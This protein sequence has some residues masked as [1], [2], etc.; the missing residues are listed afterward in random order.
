MKKIQHPLYNRWRLIRYHTTVETSQRWQAYG[1]RG[2]KMKPQWERDFWAFARWVEKHIGLPQG[3]DDYLDRIDND[4]GYYPGNLCWATAKENS[5]RTR[6]NTMIKIGRQTR[7]LSD[8]CDITG[9][10]MST[11]LGRLHRGLTYAEAFEYKNTPRVRVRH[12]QW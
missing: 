6:T 9:I 11:I 3:T 10:S 4:Q 1:G 8:W 12:Y 5:R 2:I 7:C